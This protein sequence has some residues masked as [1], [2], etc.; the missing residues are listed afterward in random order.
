MSSKLV[1]VGV[2]LVLVIVGEAVV[3]SVEEL[4]TDSVGELITDSMEVVSVAIGELVIDPIDAPKDPGIREQ[5]DMVSV[6]VRV[7]GPSAD[8]E[9]T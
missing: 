3:E 4:V 9:P 1:G 8:S 5:V 2:E 7:T 6:T